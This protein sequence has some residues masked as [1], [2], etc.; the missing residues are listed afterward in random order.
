MPSERRRGYEE[1][2]FAGAFFKKS[3]QGNRKRENRRL[4]LIIFR[5]GKLWNR[6]S[7]KGPD[8][9]VAVIQE[10]RHQNVCLF[11]AD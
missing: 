5:R 11:G 6:P 8:A 1:Q 7:R 2:C 3:R 4:D 10:S 9:A